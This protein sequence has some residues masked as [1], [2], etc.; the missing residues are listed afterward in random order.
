MNADRCIIAENLKNIRQGK[1]VQSSSANRTL[2][3]CRRPDDRLRVKVK[4]V[5]ALDPSG[6][7]KSVV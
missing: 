7:A 4:G 1:S 5:D 6:P 2:I 3:S